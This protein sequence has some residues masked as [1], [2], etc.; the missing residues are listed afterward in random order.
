MVNITN[1][2]EGKILKAWFNSNNKIYFTF[3]YKKGAAIYNIKNN[4]PAHQHFFQIEIASNQQWRYFNKIYNNVYFSSD[5]YNTDAFYSSL[6]TLKFFK[7]KFEEIFKIKNKNKILKKWKKYVTRQLGIK[8][9]NKLLKDLKQCN[10]IRTILSFWPIELKYPRPW[11]FYGETEFRYI[12]NL[13]YYNYF[14]LQEILTANFEEEAPALMGKLYGLWKTSIETKRIE[15][16]KFLDTEYE[17]TYTTN[18]TEYRAEILIVKD[19]I[20]KEIGNIDYNQYKTPN[21]LFKFWPTLL[22]PGPSF[23]KI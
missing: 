5:T 2:P 8:L 23:I 19:A 14:P 17:E 20:E 18:D 6:R 22:C 3:V 16:Q 9:T 1:L 12:E 13:Q 11:T 4:K 10:D 21:S 15:A 7:I